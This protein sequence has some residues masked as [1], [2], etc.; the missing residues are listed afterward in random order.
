MKLSSRRYLISFLSQNF[1]T[2][3]HLTQFNIVLVVFIVRLQWSTRSWLGNLLSF[4]DRGSLHA[5]VFLE[6]VSLQCHRRGLVCWERRI[7]CSTCSPCARATPDFQYP[8]KHR[9]Y[10]D[11]EYSNPS[12]CFFQFFAPGGDNG[13]D[14]L[15]AHRLVN[16][17]EMAKLV[18]QSAAL[19]RYVISVSLFPIRSI[20]N[21]DF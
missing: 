16:S 6:R 4:S 8:R 1:S 2:G 14:H 20:C 10:H 12:C 15:R 3:M 19:G 11:I 17:W 13:P 18:R 5:S 21:S 7:Y 9:C